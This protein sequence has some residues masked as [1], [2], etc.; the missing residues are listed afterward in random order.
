MATMEK[1]ALL[2]GI[3]PRVPSGVVVLKEGLSS[4]VT[5]EGNS[6]FLVHGS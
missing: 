1:G 5:K 3:L 2:V 4:V 6:S